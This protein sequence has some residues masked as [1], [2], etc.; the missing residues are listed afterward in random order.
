MTEELA[1][2]EL[3]RDTRAVHFDER[4][5]GA[6]ALRMDLARDELLADARLTEHE[7]RGLG[8]RDRLEPTCG[9][10]VPGR[11]PVDELVIDPDARDE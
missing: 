11:P 10:G 7:D 9:A 3:A 6:A 8:A 2:E 1:L 4:T 5:G